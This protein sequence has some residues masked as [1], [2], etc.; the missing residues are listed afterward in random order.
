[1]KPVAK[2]RKNP[3]AV[4]PPRGRKMSLPE[5]VEHVNRKFG[6]ALARLAK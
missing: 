4:I 2:A 3:P 5:A 6:K 1:M